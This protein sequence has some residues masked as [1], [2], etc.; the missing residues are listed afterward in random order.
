VA[1]IAAA[2][3]GLV[4]TGFVT[5]GLIDQPTASAPSTTAAAASVNSTVQPDTPLLNGGDEE[6]VA[7]VAKALGPSVVVIKTDGGLGSGV[8]Y[9]DAGLI[10]TNA[11]V[12][13]SATT[14]DVTL[15]GGQTIEGT[16]LGAD[17]GTDI[18][19]VKVTDTS[20]LKAARLAAEPSEVGDLTVALGS[21]FGL[22]RTVTAGV[23]SA[24]DRPVD[25]GAGGFVNMIQTDA[26]INPGNSG[27]ALANRRAEVIGINSMIY[28]ES[29]DSAGIGFAIPIA[30][31][32]AVADAIVN[33]GALERGQLGVSVQPTSDGQ[34][35]GQVT[36]VSPGSAAEQAGVQEG[37]V[38]TEV[39]GKTIKSS[40]DVAGAIGAKNAGDTVELTIS[41]NG[42]TTTVTA[43]LDPKAATPSTT[44]PDSG[45]G[46]TPRS[47]P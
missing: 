16:V 1:L 23:V 41:R 39:D 6:P 15:D 36:A 3:A 43:T 33:G 34:P 45:S 38:I 30:K 40:D 18:A 19:V 28:S 35:G 4:T 31:A 8:V 9:D 21:P 17:T 2:V 42:T 22:Q 27:G 24:I 37:D 14:V 7:A 25:N 11:H 26:P 12:V 13:G 44:T 29:G 20:N 10:I 32:K 47:T 46:R 5:R